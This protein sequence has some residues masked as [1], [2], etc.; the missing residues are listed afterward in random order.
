MNESD[1]KLHFDNVLEFEN[2][3]FKYNDK[4]DGFKFSDLNLKINKGDVI[5][6]V[7]KTGTGKSTLIDLILGLLKPDHGDIKVDNKS[8]L[9]IRHSW[10]QLIGYV[11]QEVFLTDDSIANNIALGREDGEINMKRIK[12]LISICNLEKLISELPDGVMNEV[13]KEELDFQEVKSKELG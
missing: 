12:D 7:G 2:I 4:H 9:N 6:I 5:G 8:I 1:L 13:E 11:P 10:N 3:A